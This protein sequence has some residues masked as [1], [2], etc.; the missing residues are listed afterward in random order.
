VLPPSVAEQLS[1]SNKNQSGIAGFLK[2][3]PVFVNKVLNQLLMLWQIRQALPWSRM[4]DP[5][6]RAA[7]QYSNPKAILFGRT[8]S[9]DEAKKLYSTLKTQV[10][11][12][13]HVSQLLT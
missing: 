1:G 3:R 10:F 11:N 12:E 7:F 4:E 5:Y 8:W 9:A 13:L 6:L 2:I